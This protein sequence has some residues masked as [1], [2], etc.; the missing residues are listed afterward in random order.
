MQ[1]VAT[2]R[3]AHPAKLSRR[4]IA[5][6][7]D[8]LLLAALL[9]VTSATF[10]AANGGEAL[11]SDHPLRPLLPPFLLLV[12]YAFFV[13]FWLRAGQTLGMRTWR[14]RLVGRDGSRVGAGP[15]SIRFVVAAAL[16]AAL[17]GAVAAWRSPDWQ[18]LAAPLALL[19]IAGY[20]WALIDR[21][22]RSWQDLASGTAIVHE[23]K[24]S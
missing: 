11:A 15:A 8:S 16:W 3:E 1:P 24:R 20:G 9:F 4:L 21:Q 17:F 19:G 5:I 12:S 23:P 2:A 6:V 13:G 18:L 22:R 7:Y 14:L 10:T